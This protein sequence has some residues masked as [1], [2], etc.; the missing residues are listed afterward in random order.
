MT[1]FGRFSSEATRT[2][3]LA[4]QEAEARQQSYIGTEHLLLGLIA[5]PDAIAH[6]VLTELGADMEKARQAIEQVRTGDERAAAGEIMPTSRVKA[7][8][9]IAFEEGRRA[10]DQYVGTEHL[11]L[12]LLIEGRGI[13]GRALQGLRVSLP[14]VRAEID[15]ERA[16]GHR[17][18]IATRPRG[19]HQAAH[20]ATGEDIPALG[21]DAVELL[22]LASAIAGVDGVPSVGLEHVVRALDDQA[23]GRL[24]RL[25]ARIRQV[26]A[27]GEEAV[28]ARDPDTVE[29]R[30]REERQLREEHARAETEWRRGLR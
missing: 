14:Q 26:V 8:I 7:A 15:R 6:R 12:G 22:H 10:G 16:Q 20:L 19:L 2:L 24:L 28:A 9:E 27:A 5:N 17:E 30:R 25:S 1:P 4:Q 11:L 29:E 3:S 18:T 13:G 21:P 23:V